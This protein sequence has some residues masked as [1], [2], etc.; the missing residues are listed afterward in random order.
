MK[1]V[2]TES[3]FKR[4]IENI[5][6]ESFPSEGSLRKEFIDIL[7]KEKYPY[8]IKN[9]KIIIGGGYINSDLITYI[10]DNVE[11]NNKGVVD[12]YYL[13]K[14][15]N[16]IVF[17]N[18]CH[19]W[20]NFLKEMGNNIQFNNKGNVWLQSLNKMGN[21]IIFNNKDNVWL[22]SIIWFNINSV[23][24]TNNVGDVYFGKELFWMNEFPYQIYNI[25]GKFQMKNK[26]G[27]WDIIK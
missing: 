6:D 19:V 4:L 14:M 24:F 17:N 20:L 12:L 7:N 27:E 8:K 10:P 22:T 15:G 21:N 11:F 25:K 2:I 5:I 9:N 1:I 13:N 26:E 16:N 23:N 3:Q 18:K